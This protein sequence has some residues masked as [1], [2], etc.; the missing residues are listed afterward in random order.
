MTGVAIDY[1]F[2]PASPW[3][4]LGHER[5][6]DSRTPSRRDD[7][8]PAGRPRPQVFPVSGGLPLA[9]RAPQRQ[10]YRLVE[11]QRFSE[12]LRP[13]AEPAASV[14][15][16]RRA[17]TPRELIIAVDA[18]DGSR[19]GDAHQRARSCAASG[20]RSG[21]SPTTP[22]LA[23]AARRARP[24]GCAGSTTRSRRPCTSATRPTRSARSTPACSARRATSSTAR[25]SGART[26]STSSSG[27]SR[28]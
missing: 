23:G 3:T 7:Q 9:K 25:S 18:H 8:R 4:Y 13:A 22:V 12:Y 27:A 15:P 11:L 17:T 10:A 2:S 14:L 24:A 16:G 20:S 5:F 6:A 26:G 1:Y 28:K 21:T 19:R